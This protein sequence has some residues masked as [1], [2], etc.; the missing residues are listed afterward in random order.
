MRSKGFQFPKTATR[1]LQDLIAIP[2]INPHGDP[3]YSKTGEQ[4]IAEY[5]AAFLKKCGADVK[6]V[7]VLPNRPNVIGF[8]G[9]SSSKNLPINFAPHLD[10]VSV[11][12]M[13]ID[14][15]AAKISQ[16]KIWGRGASDTKGPMAAMLWALKIWSEKFPTQPI[17]VAFTGLMGE[18]A[19]NEGAIDLVQSNFKTQF[20]II[21]EP[22]DLKIVHAHK[23]ALW[24]ELK[25]KGKSCHAS[26]PERGKNAIL[27]MTEAIEKIQKEFIPFLS[28]HHHPLLGK[29]S[30]NLG[31]ISGGSKVNIVPSSC[32]IECDIRTIP[33]CGIREIETKLQKILKGLPDISYKIHRSPNAL[34]TDPKNVWIQKLKPFTQ[35]LTVA[36]WF[37]DAAVFAR[38]KVPAVALGPG[39]IRQAHTVD[40]YILEKEFLKGVTLFEKFLTSITPKTK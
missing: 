27:A 3:G 1:L 24:F 4:Q 35:G 22:T 16:C 33:N 25:A 7:P 19:G 12:G 14:P 2:S 23:G 32:V 28:S 10:T 20:A 38:H 11:L 5:V 30:F 39:S 40:E 26:T 6:L 15:F 13:T 17:P 8:F 31:T 21:G 34:D 18:E 37:C 36:P 9:R 29:P